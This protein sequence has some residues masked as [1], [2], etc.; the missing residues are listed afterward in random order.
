[1]FFI[2]GKYMAKVMNEYKSYKKLKTSSIIIML[3]LLPVFVVPLF[4]RPDWKITKL[5]PLVICVAA[6][7]VGLTAGIVLWAFCFIYG[8]A[9]KRLYLT[10]SSLD[11]DTYV[12]FNYSVPDRPDSKVDVIIISRKGIYCVWLCNYLIGWVNG[13][14]KKNKWRILTHDHVA[15]IDNPFIKLKEKIKII[16]DYMLSRGCSVDITPMLV[17]QNGMN[18]SDV[19]SVLPVMNLAS[20]YFWQ[21]YKLLHQKKGA[22]QK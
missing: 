2:G 16:S 22:D 15:Y 5:D 9:S 3:V 19:S 7:A 4:L 10:L 14:D 8:G 12:Y 20:Q 6:G 13:D 17:F 21:G 1:M 11:D 18:L